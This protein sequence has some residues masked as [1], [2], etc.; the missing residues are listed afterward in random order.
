MMRTVAAE[1][2]QTDPRTIAA[3]FRLLWIL[4]H[5]AL[6]LSE[7]AEHQSVSLPT[8]SNSVT[9]L[10]ERGWVTRRRSE[11]DRRKV[12]IEITAAGQAVL[13]EV[14]QHMEERVE[15]AI[16]DLDPARQETVSE[17]L[18]ILRDC[19]E[20]FSETACHHANQEKRGK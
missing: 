13:A 12:V 14:G 9:N 4:R 15:A 16:H 6:S 20:A 3:H 1:M 18:L 8:M 10:E 17:A 7:L 5:H 11:D 19:F 2:R